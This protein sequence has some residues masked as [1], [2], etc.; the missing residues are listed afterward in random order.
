MHK[1]NNHTYGMET[2]TCF[3]IFHN[4]LLLWAHAQLVAQSSLQNFSFAINLGE[5]EVWV[6]ASSNS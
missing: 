2:I 5:R 4:R 6:N 3:G 1:S